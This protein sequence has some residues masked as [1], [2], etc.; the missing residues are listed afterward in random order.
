MSDGGA[1]HTGNGQRSVSGNNL[2]TGTEKKVVVLIDEYDTPIIHYLGIDLVKAQQNRE[3]LKGFYGILKELD[4]L[5]ELVFLTGVS[6]FSKV[7]IFLWQS[8][9]YT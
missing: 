5:I 4:A 2:Q 8:A 3:L 9:L 1:S 7:G 6:K